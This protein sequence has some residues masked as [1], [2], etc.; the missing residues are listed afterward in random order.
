[1]RQPWLSVTTPVYNGEV[2]LSTA[3]DSVIMQKGNNIEYIAEDVQS[4]DTTLSIP[5]SYLSKLSLK[6]LRLERE[7]NWVMRFG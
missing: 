7:R 1:M 4:T 6:I 5:R 3:L 2:Y